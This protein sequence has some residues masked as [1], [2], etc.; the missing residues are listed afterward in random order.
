[1]CIYNAISASFFDIICIFGFSQQMMRRKSKLNHRE[2][3]LLIEVNGNS[4][5][6]WLKIFRLN[7]KAKKNRKY[8]WITVWFLESNCKTIHVQFIVV[9][10][11]IVKFDR[12]VLKKAEITAARFRTGKAKEKKFCFKKTKQRRREKKRQCCLEWLEMY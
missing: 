2:W 5:V 8:Y 11:W 9:S 12:I 6:C 7:K 1:M 10:K 4:C 3:K